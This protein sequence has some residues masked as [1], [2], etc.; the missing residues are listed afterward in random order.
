MCVVLPA[1]FCLS[2]IAADFPSY[3][4]CVLA[5]H[6]HM[7]SCHLS[8]TVADC[9]SC[10]RLQICLIAL[11]ASQSAAEQTL[12]YLLHPTWLLT[13]SSRLPKHAVWLSCDLAYLCCAED[14][15]ACNAPEPGPAG[16]GACQR[17]GGQARGWVAGQ[18]DRVPSTDMSWSRRLYICE[19][20]LFGQAGGVSAAATPWFDGFDFVSRSCGQA[21]GVPSSRRNPM[22]TSVYLG[23]L[24]GHLC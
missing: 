14:A 10:Y 6:P 16:N 4:A 21:Y 23:S 24:S 5:A 12:C 11:H 3:D 1:A 13:V 17:G 19:W 20:E 7:A 15:G 22:D 9:S 8:L 18:A 2:L